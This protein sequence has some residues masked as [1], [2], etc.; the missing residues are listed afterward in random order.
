M[1]LVEV[2]AGRQVVKKG[3]RNF[4]YIVLAGELTLTDPNELCPSPS[5]RKVQNQLSRSALI[6]LENS[7]PE[8]NNIEA[9]ESFGDYHMLTK[10][11]R[12]WK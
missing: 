6:N 8:E 5:V 2:Q 1:K 3:D 11:H 4:L 10:R 9:G 12:T 7:K